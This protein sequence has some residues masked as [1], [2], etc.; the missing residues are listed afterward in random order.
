MGEQGEMV[1]LGISGSIRA[2]SNN[3]AILETLRERLIGTATMTL[4]PLSDI[5]PY[6]SDEDGDR[7]PASVL[8]LKAAIAEADGIVL[9][10][11]E[12]NHGTSGVLKNALDWASRP[13]FN[14]P[15]KNKPA[16][17]MTSS[18]GMIGGVRAH[19]QLR[20]T[21][22]SAFARVMAGPQVV[23]SGVLQKVADG[24]LTD[25]PTI[26]FALAAIAEM[27]REVRM[28]RLMEAA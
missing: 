23:V 18:P 3:T 8:R 11:P 9:C 7:C 5:P 10:S 25:E 20:D 12:Y 26:A 22:A 28:L 19:Q 27:M 13:A 14:S 4:F 24:R 17:I 2:A 6:N 1:L 16:L 21:L 15:L